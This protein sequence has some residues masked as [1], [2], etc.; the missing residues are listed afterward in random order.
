MTWQSYS[1]SVK[2]IAK[3]LGGLKGPMCMLNDLYTQILI[4]GDNN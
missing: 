3:C 1:L 4:P 2:V